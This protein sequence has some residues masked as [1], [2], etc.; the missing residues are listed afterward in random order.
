MRERSRSEKMGQRVAWPKPSPD[1]ISEKLGS[2]GRFRSKGAKWGQSCQRS[3]CRVSRRHYLLPFL[4]ST[5]ND[6]K[7]VKNPEK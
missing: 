3:P 7:S 5:L 6:F 2:T 1:E 4:L